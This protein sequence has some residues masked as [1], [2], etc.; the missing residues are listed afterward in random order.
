M[1]GYLTLAGES[2]A[3]IIEKKSR[4]I[5]RAA[6]AG[7]EGAA[8]SFI[9]SVKKIERDASHNVYAYRVGIGR[10]YEKY[11]D[12]GEPSG[13]AGRPALS[14]LQKELIT[15]AVVVVTRYF[16]G[17]MLGAGGLTRAYQAAAKAGVGAA[18]V[19][20]MRLYETYTVKTPY[21]YYGRLQRDEAAGGY[22]LRGATYGE[23]VT[24]AVHTPRENAEAFI[25]LIGEM[26]NGEAV[27]TSGGAVFESAGLKGAAL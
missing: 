17:I 26:T 18:G 20:L 16:G 13:T 9:E 12:D 8:L 7:D 1:D 23:E 24:V 6:P 2:S 25:K 15:N 3:E 22:S 19:S 21:S 14:V 27:V 4:F 5:A 11:F 10:I